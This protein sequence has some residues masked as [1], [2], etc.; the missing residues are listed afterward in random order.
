MRENHVLIAIS[1]LFFAA[2]NSVAVVATAERR[3]ER[4]EVLVTYRDSHYRSDSKRGSSV[5]AASMRASLQTRFAALEKNVFGE[6]RLDKDWAVQTLWIVGGSSARLTQDEIRNLQANP[7]VLSV[8]PL[9]RRGQLFEVGS[10]VPQHLRFFWGAVPSF[11]YGLEKIGVPELLKKRPDLDGTGVRVGIIDTGIDA[12]HPELKGRLL[13]YRDFI[14]PKIK[15]ARDDNGHGT[16]VAG[17]VGGGSLSGTTI[18]VAP[19]VSFLSAKAFS[20]Y[21]GSTE[22]GMLAALQWM[23]DPDGDPATNDGANV[24]NC[25]WNLDDGDIGSTDA[26]TDPFC[27]A[28]DQL[29]SLG[30]LTVFS[31]GN[32]GSGANTIK[33]P[34]AC[35]NALTV[36]S[37]DDN[38]DITRTSSRGPSIWKSGS[39]NKPDVMAPGQDID[40]TWKGGGYRTKSGTSMS[41]PHVVGAAALMLQAKPNQTAMELKEVLMNTADDLGVVGFDFDSGAGRINIVKAIESL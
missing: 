16:H 18:G 5:S 19:K 6:K 1:V 24:V 10:A 23:A 35:Q 3:S 33:I 25:S 14:D 29:A 8:K 26:S 2:I 40:S 31:A 15:T 12:T 7:D 36:G 21:G 22:S 11:T 13:N 41:V 34:G 17:T 37:T 39:L 9:K 32:D 28:I 20:K 30:V 27:V 38:D 4:V